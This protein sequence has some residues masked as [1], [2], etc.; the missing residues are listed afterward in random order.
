[1]MNTAVELPR[2][3]SHAVMFSVMPFGPSQ[4]MSRKKN[5]WSMSIFRPPSKSNPL[6]MCQIWV[7]YWIMEQT[8]TMIATISWVQV[9]PERG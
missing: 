9:V 6:R 3:C 5:F 2:A 4:S 1:M 8:L 7:K